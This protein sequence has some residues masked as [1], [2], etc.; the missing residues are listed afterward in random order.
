LAISW[1]HHDF[2]V[3]QR[4]EATKPLYAAIDPHSSNSALSVMDGKGKAL[5][6][7]R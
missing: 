6:Q 7:S 5:L 1:N 4:Q 2:D 3:A